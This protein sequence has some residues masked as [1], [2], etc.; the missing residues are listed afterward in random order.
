MTYAN[1]FL[2]NAADERRAA[3]RASMPN[4]RDNHLKAAL[5]WE[6]LAEEVSREFAQL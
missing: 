3:A 2:Q 1:G 6:A 5:R 4:V